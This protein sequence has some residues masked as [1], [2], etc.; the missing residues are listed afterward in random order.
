MVK[1]GGEFGAGNTGDTLQQGVGMWHQHGRIPEENEGIF[2]EI[3]DI[4]SGWYDY[5][6][7]E[8][9]SKSNSKILSLADLV[10]FPKGHQKRIGELAERTIIR[11]AIVAVP[12]KEEE[13]RRKY[14]KID[15]EDFEL[16]VDNY[17][18]NKESENTM[19]RSIIDM[20][21]YMKTYMI[22]PEMDFL[23]R[24]G[25]D[26][27]AMYF[28]EFKHELT[29][30]D[31]ADLWQNLPPS[32][33]V[34]H[35]VAEVEVSHELLSNELLGTKRKYTNA[36]NIIRNNKQTLFDSDIQWMVFKVKQRADKSYKN[37]MYGQ[38]KEKIG[39]TYNWPYDYFSLVELIKIE[40]EVELSDIQEQDGRRKP[41]KIISKRFR[42][43]NIDI[44]G[45][46]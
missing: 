20:V 3:T 16:A 30:Q 19:G 44:D 15:K 35:E 25:I 42:T 2:I 6:K 11:E 39:D 10:G 43:G 9:Y 1:I 7:G 5:V 41:K 12:F 29:K 17:E 38:Q 8:I 18:K 26:P 27:F 34:E 4:P 24:K 37:L 22:P 23:T 28:F 14:Y 13:G 32:I 21:E 36:A 45:D 40:A 31:L 46:S 33:G